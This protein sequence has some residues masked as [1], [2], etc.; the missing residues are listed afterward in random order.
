MLSIYNEQ[1]I[2][3]DVIE[4]LLDNGLNVV[5]LDNGSTDRSFAICSELAARRGFVLE[6]WDPV[7]LDL[8]QL[9]LRLFRLAEKQKPDW[10]IFSDGDEIME[11]GRSGCTLRRAIEEADAAGYNLMQYNRFDFFMSDQDDLSVSSPVHRMHYYSWQGDF[12]YRAFKFL[13]G[14][15]AFPSFAHYPL[16]APE[17]PYKVAPEKLV[18]RHYPY[19]SRE[20]AGRKI[21]N[22]VKKIK[23]DPGE[24]ESWQQR[25]LRIAEEGEHL[26]PVDHCLLNRYY[27]DHN[28]IA[29]RIYTPF[30]DTQLTKDQLLTP[31]GFLRNRPIPTIDWT[32]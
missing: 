28:W 2:I 17:Y 24:L 19:R 3:S 14:L 12:N 21:D 22:L 32:T 7:G 25:Y 30:T 29:E 20:H 26:L 16:F 27:D 23:A 31:E 5:A 18:L 4:N 10:L 9:T 1:D 8:E 11:T 13:P 6:R 15:Q